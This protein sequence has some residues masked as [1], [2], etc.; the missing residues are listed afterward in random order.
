MSRAVLLSRCVMKVKRI[1][2]KTLCVFGAL[3]LSLLFV[4]QTAIF[5]VKAAENE[6]VYT[7]VLEDLQKDENFNV[8]TYPVV[9]NDYSLQVIQIAESVNKELFVYMYQPSAGVKDLT[10][11]TIRM[12]MPVVGI[13]TT[14]QDYDLTLLNKNGVFQKY[15]VEDIIVKEDSVRYYD[16]TAIHRSFDDTIDEAPTTNHEN[17]TNEIAYAVGQQWTALTVDGS[18]SYSMIEVE[19][20]IITDK[21]VGYIRYDEGFKLY[22]DKCDSHFVAFSTDRK[23]ERLM[24]ADVAFVSQDYSAV[25][26]VIGGSGQPTYKEPVDNF[27]SLSEIDTASNDGDGL[28]GKT[29]TW[30]RIEKVSTFLSTENKED[31]NLTDGNLEDLEK[32]QWI[33]RFTETDYTVSTGSVVSMFGTKV[34]EVTILR[35]Y[36]E[37]DGKLYNLGVVDNKTTGSNNPF[38]DADTKLDDF[39]EEMDKWWEVILIAF[40]LLGIGIFLVFVVSILWPLLWPLLVSVGKGLVK[41]IAKGI[42]FLFKAAWVIIT[43]P[44]VLIGKLFGRKDK[45][46]YRE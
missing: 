21:V 29:Y 31:L 36:F 14:W 30:N 23:M 43:L 3:L 1:L 26:G 42:V 24:E 16:I 40:I 5:P 19:V 28:F 44:F 20:I 4:F 8:E 15:K 9:E 46:D 34:S 45:P 6:V 12:S 25:Y 13:N 17:V 39:I 18:V 11:T 37:T 33:L 22:V 38:A 10:A 32:M 7:D 27:V 35:L 41:W 2:H